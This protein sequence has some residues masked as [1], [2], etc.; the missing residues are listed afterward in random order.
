MSPGWSWTK[1]LKISISFS[2]PMPAHTSSPPRQ[3]PK[4]DDRLQHE[5]DLVEGID[6]IYR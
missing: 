6:A 4:T 5:V 2:T 3:Q 1:Y